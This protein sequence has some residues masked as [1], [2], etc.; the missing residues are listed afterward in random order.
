VAVDAAAGVENAAAEEVEVERLTLAL[1][2]AA[3]IRTP[4]DSS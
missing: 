1:E 4:N 3:R 2:T